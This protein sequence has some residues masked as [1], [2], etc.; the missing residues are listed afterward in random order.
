MEQ[1]EF[2]P[3]TYYMQLNESLKKPDGTPSDY[4][5]LMFN[6]KHYRLGSTSYIRSKDDLYNE[7]V[8][9]VAQN[10]EPRL[11]E[12]ISNLE[13]YTITET[14]FG[15]TFERYITWND[16][17][18]EFTVVPKGEHTNHECYTADISLYAPIDVMAKFKRD[19]NIAKLA[20]Q[21]D[22]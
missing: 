9:R 14:D 20:L 2:E 6:N 4:D 17:E 15:W 5:R 21:Y 18:T 11:D 22:V 3:Q 1:S 10:V 7:V 19:D 13:S 16:D 12:N 8:K